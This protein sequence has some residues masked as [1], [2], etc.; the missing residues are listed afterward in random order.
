M[1]IAA[2]VAATASH[3]A[4]LGL[5]TQDEAL[6]RDAFAA[7]EDKNWPKAR[8]LAVQADLVLP[9]KVIYWL[10][11][12]REK[13]KPDFDELATFLLSNPDW[14]SQKML[15]TKAEQA[16]DLAMPASAVIAWFE[17]FPPV[18]RQ[19]RIR[20][21]QALDAT[22]RTA[23]AVDLLRRIWIEE[24]FPRRN[25]KVFY[26]RYKSILRPE[27]HIARL[28][29]L[30]WDGRRSE[31][32]R[33]LRV[34]E[35]GYAALGEARIRLMER[36][37][38]VDQAVAAVPVELRDDPGLW[39]ERLRWRRRK[40]QDR[41]DE[42]AREILF[43]P[44]IEL[45]RPSAW[46]DERGILARRALEDG[47]VSEAYRLAS[48]H[49]QTEGLDFAD[50]E[51]LAGWIALRFLGD[52]KVAYGHFATMRQAVRYPIST[53]RAAY[54]AGRALEDLGERESA[55]LWYA[56][57]AQHWETYYGQ[58]AG[59]CLN[60]LGVDIRPGNIEP[61]DYSGATIGDHE[62]A[63]VV[64]LLVYLDEVE[65]IDDFILR[66]V[67]LAETP[68]DQAFIAML[69]LA[70]DR[71]DLSTAAA[72]RAIKHGV[73]LVANAYPLVDLPINGDQ[74]GLED[75]LVLAVIRRES[76]FDP[77]AIS[78]AGARGLMQLMPATARQV[79]RAMRL[80]ENTAT[81]TEDPAYNVTLAQPSSRA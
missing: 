38:A 81:L 24:N 1:A 28:D 32:K 54:W 37:W 65:R 80:P 43:A 6:Y 78:S 71:P 61:L 27:D 10:D 33:M 39:Y 40:N 75:A 52:A 70:S 50:A 72:R 42:S 17:R 76:A 2:I 63:N 74:A 7:I 47:Y 9:A 12:T 58:L 34:V 77:E 59:G 13:S 45:V 19:G 8:S 16:M 36:G 20:L 30:L 46:W 41:Y 68:E 35:S 5:S 14:P 44:P 51:W 57:A 23:E 11:L 69:A 26:A 49:G 60:A 25:S 66:L 15:R 48:E 3:A 79:A 73:N 18:S 21:A 22:Q 64:R 55:R 31:A 67:A 4:A 53:A 56:D 29:R 62:L